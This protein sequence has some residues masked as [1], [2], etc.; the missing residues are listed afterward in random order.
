MRG[1]LCP[2]AGRASSGAPASGAAKPLPALPL[3]RGHKAGNP[4]SRSKAKLAPIG[5]TCGARSSNGKG[6]ATEGR[7][8]C[9]AHTHARTHTEE[10]ALPSGIALA[11]IH[12]R[13]GRPTTFP[14]PV[15]AAIIADIQKESGAGAGAGTHYHAAVMS[16]SAFGLA[17]R[18]A[19]SDV[20]LLQYQRRRTKGRRKMS[21][22]VSIDF[23]RRT[24]E[25]SRQ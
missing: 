18:A 16:A 6:K 15:N 25:A 3:Q 22:T 13:P 24:L 17:R 20:V 5:N 9:A 2:G 7:D 21:A 11:L 1:V 4:P 23:S 10:G 19:S 14:F 12:R 8:R